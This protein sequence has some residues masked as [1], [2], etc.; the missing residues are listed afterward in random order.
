MDICFGMSMAGSSKQ[1]C[2][3]A[4][5]TAFDVKVV[6]MIECWSFVRLGCSE[7]IFK[8]YSP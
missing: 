8:N 4:P 6:L 7:V 1:A 3:R 5:A 2:G